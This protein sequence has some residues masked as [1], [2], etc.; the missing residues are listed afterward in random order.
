MYDRIRHVRNHFRLQASGSKNTFNSKCNVDFVL[1]IKK[2]NF[3]TCYYTHQ[4]FS[5]C[6]NFVSIRH[7]CFDNMD[8]C[9]IHKQKLFFSSVWTFLSFVEGFCSS[10]SS[11]FLFLSVF[12]FIDGDTSDGDFA[13]A[14]HREILLWI[15]FNILTYSLSIRSNFYLNAVFPHLNIFLK[16]L[17][18]FSIFL[19]D[20]CSL[21]PTKWMSSFVPSRFY[22]S[23]VI[24]MYH[25]MN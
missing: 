19:S 3:I 10:S 4:F 12:P 11:F 25:F 7:L 13:A 18:I 22:L 15:P 8:L 6:F 17:F 5:I 14:R 9:E 16:C 23:N 24:S 20:E 21:D 2:S 1:L